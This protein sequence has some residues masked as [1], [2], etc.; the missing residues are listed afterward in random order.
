[1]DKKKKKESQ[2]YVISEEE[3]TQLLDQEAINF[4]REFCKG[5][6]VAEIYV[7]FDDFTSFKLDAFFKNLGLKDVFAEFT[8]F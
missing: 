1:M 6:F 5:P 8:H 4:F 3:G 7:K 2:S